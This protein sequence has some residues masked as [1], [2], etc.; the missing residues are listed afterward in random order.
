MNKLSIA[1]VL[2]FTSAV[3]VSA[4][5]QPV[6]VRGMMYAS[7]TASPVQMMRGEVRA[8]PAVRVMEAKPTEG[9]NRGQTVTF[10]AHAMPAEMMTP[11]TGDPAI[12]AQL[13]V[14]AKEMSEKMKAINDDY[15]A[16]VKALVGTRVLRYGN[17]IMASTTSVMPMRAMD[18]VQLSSTTRGVMM[19]KVGMD[20][21]GNQMETV[22]IS[23]DGDQMIMQGERPMRVQMSPVRNES[24]TS[25]GVGA[26]FNSMFRGMFG[27]N[28]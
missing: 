13:K 17:V 19:R 21:N 16:K 12:D 27:G 28:K 22:T 5:E 11:T 14:L 23:A 6:A 26:Q 3:S 2:M 10:S 7:A 18:V 25:R 8:M 15:Q 4:L 20:A 9:S 24:D 1:S